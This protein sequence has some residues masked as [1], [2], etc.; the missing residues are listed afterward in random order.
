MSILRGLSGAQNTSL[1]VCPL[2]HWAEGLNACLDLP[3][4]LFLLDY[5]R[6]FSI[7]LWSSQSPASCDAWDYS[8]PGTPCWVSWG[9]FWP[10]RHI[11]RGLFQMKVHFLAWHQQLLSPNLSLDTHLLKITLLHYP[12]CQCRCGVSASVSTPTKLRFSLAP[13]KHQ[14]C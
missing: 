1:Q 6:S 10:N 9:W 5:S 3:A 4:V 2:Q 14:S 12:D 11:S 13:A 7:D 8:T